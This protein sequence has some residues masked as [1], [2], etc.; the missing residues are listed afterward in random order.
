MKEK[1]PGGKV[2]GGVF[3]IASVIIAGCGEETQLPPEGFT[4]D[5]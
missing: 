3:L 2:L 4:R 1:L 5:P